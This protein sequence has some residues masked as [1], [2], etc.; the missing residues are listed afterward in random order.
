MKKYLVIFLITCAFA[1]HEA[2]RYPVTFNYTHDQWNAHLDTLGMLDYY[3]GKPMMHS[4]AEILRAWVNRM[5]GEIT[6]Q[7]KEEIK[8][9]TLKK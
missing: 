8:K 4:D 5:K 1:P 9:D 3:I 6:R 7:V 2:K